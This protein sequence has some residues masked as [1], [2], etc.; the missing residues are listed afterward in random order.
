MNISET[1]TENIYS[2]QLTLLDHLKMKTVLDVGSEL[3]K[4]QCENHLGQ[5][6]P[7]FLLYLLDTGE[8]ILDDERVLEIY[9]KVRHNFFSFKSIKVSLLVNVFAIRAKPYLWILVISYITNYI[10]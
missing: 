4:H 3:Q 10:R 9:E 7:S 5:L 6:S 2:Y 1:D 8:L